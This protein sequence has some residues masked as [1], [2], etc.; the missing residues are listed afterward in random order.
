[1]IFQ[2]TPNDTPLV[3]AQVS[4]TNGQGD[5]DLNAAGGWSELIREIVR[6]SDSGG[7]RVEV[8]CIANGETAGS[9]RTFSAPIGSTATEPHSESAPEPAP[10]LKPVRIVTDPSAP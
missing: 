3:D 1:M 8:R 9:G 2:P 5:I 4:S 7:G 10:N 6:V